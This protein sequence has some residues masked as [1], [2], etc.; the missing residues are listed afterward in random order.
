MKRIP[1]FAVD[2]YD[3]HVIRRI[4]NDFE[5]E[6][7]DAVRAFL[8]SETHGLLERIENGMWDYSEYGIYDMWKA[9]QRTGDPRNSAYMRGE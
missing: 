7:M 1:Y 8:T 5:M 2:Y 6:Q 3:R 9:E 4:V